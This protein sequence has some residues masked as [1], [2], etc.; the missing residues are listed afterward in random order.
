MQPIITCVIITKL[1]YDI[2]FVG[3]EKNYVANTINKKYIRTGND[4]YLGDNKNNNTNF[5]ITNRKFFKIIANFML[6]YLR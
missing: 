3:V 2:K 5:S 1:F 4:V 6:L